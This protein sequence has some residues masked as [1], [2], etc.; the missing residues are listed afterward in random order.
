[1]N[2]LRLP[3][4]LPLALGQVNPVQA[5]LA[6]L[7]LSGKI[8]AIGGLVGIVAVFLPLIS[9]SIQMPGGAS[10]G[11][12]HGVN[13]PAVSSSQSI[14][15]IGDFRG[16]LCLMGYACALAFTYVLYPPNGLSQ[17]A[18]GWAGAGVG[19]FI[20]LLALWLLVG[21]YSGSGGLSGFGSSF[22][23]SLG[24]G[25]ILNLLAGVTV[26]AGGVIK[27]REEQLI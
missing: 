6:R 5:W 23:I 1:M 26:A 15:V 18:L 24:I 3:F 27:A 10:F 7:G 11:G 20:S 16:I 12:K 17:K 13:I 4:W 2:R 22:K 8:L 21:A 19:A 9:M 14:L 25:A